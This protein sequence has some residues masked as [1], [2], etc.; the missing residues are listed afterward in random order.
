MD[1]ALDSCV[2][3]PI[4]GKAIGIP[5]CRVLLVEERMEA[6]SIVASPNSPSGV[7]DTFDD[8]AWYSCLS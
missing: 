4:T 2:N 1:I 5:T 8:P 6:R 3:K 7:I